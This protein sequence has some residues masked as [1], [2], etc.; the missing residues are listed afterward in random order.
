MCFLNKFEKKNIYI[1]IAFYFN[2]IIIDVFLKHLKI[3]FASKKFFRW[4]S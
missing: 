4:L 3:F 2:K 1:H